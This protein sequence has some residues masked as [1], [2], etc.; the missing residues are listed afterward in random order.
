VKK[1]DSEGF[2]FAKTICSLSIHFLLITLNS[3]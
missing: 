1:G 3:A 2:V